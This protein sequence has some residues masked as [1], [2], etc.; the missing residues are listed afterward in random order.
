VM[1]LTESAKKVNHFV[2][3]ALAIPFADM[4]HGVEHRWESEILE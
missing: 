2:S 4:L 1:I 3:N